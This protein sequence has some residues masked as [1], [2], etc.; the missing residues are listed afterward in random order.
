MSKS[1]DLSGKVF[2]RLTVLNRIENDSHGNAQWL[3]RCE[4]GKETIVNGTRLLRGI[5]KSC[6]CLRRD[7]RISANTTHG[8][9]KTR[10]YRIWLNMKNRCNNKKHI[11]EDYRGR[12][13]S[14]CD[15]W[16]NSFQSFFDWATS[17]GYDDEKS[18][19]RIDNNGNYKPENCRWADRITQANNNRRNFIIRI[20]DK[21]KTLAQ[22]VRLSG[23]NYSTLFSKIQRGEMDEVKAMISQKIEMESLGTSSEEMKEAV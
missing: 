20:G 22:W 1:I 6:G 7:S 17:N 2:S 8:K 14:V 18:I 4:C 21:D 3:C 10:L 13:I 23:L 19:D 16:N 12:G 9:K 5:I 15:S 11:R